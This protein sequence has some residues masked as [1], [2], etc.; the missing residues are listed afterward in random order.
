M[1]SR[2][3]AACARVPPLAETALAGE[4]IM[5]VEVRD[6]KMWC[7]DCGDWHDIV[8]Y[9]K[10]DLRVVPCPRV[11]P[12]RILFLEE[13]CGNIRIMRAKDFA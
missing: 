5:F 1:V 8:T 2:L 4:V 10:T 13:V 7:D 6:G 9:E 11:P 3:V 12:D